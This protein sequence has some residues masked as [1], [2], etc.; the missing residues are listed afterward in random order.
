MIVQDLCNIGR[1]ARIPYFTG[2]EGDDRDKEH[3]KLLR[4]ARRAMTQDDKNEAAE[5][6]VR[7]MAGGS[8]DHKEPEA[9]LRIRKATS[10]WIAN[11]R[12]GFN[13]RVIRRTVE[14]KTFD[15]K[16]IN[17]T[18]TP[19]KMIVVPVH[20]DESELDINTSVMAQITGSCVDGSLR[21]LRPFTDSISQISG[22][23]IG[24]QCQLQ[25][26]MSSVPSGSRS[27]TV[28]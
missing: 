10:A 14:S 15:N 9:R 11:I 8:T 19:Y 6:T 27:L 28:L 16:K 22:R 21:G 23:D 4:A 26:G 18:L 20:L 17:D 12:R 13:G 2:H 24:R 7:L 25:H 1:L 3:M 5:H